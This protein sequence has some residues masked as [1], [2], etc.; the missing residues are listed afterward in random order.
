[1]NLSLFDKAVSE[2]SMVFFPT[3]TWLP[4]G[5]ATNQMAVQQILTSKIEAGNCNH[6]ASNV[7]QVKKS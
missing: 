3:K 2:R 6:P 7:F 5:S 1:M 4:I